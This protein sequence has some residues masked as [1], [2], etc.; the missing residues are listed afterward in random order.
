MMIR[1]T[2]KKFADY[3][4]RQPETGMGYRV[5]TRHL[6]DG[7]AFERVIVDSGYITKV[8]G[9]DEVPFGETKIDHFVIT[10]E[11]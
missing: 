7:R 6:K 8:R 3:F 11:R 2:Q 9:Y 10:P 5:A 4:R 1:L